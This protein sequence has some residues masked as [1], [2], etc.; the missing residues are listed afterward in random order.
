M[1]VVRDIV[2]FP[3]RFIVLMLKGYKRWISPFLPTACRF[4]P[5][6]SEYAMQV[7]ATYGIFYGGYLALI[8]LLKCHPFH[9]G[10]I[11]MPPHPKANGRLQR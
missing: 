6:C 7:I 2:S 11:D 9:S 5:T 8:R 1:I 3:A 10:G 4:Y